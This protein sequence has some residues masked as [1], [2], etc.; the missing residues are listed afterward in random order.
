MKHRFANFADFAE[1]A[2]FADFDDFTDSADFAD[3]ADFT[4]SADSP[5]FHAPHYLLMVSYLI[6]PAFQN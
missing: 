2:H 5:S 3:S 6:A 4:D 1:S